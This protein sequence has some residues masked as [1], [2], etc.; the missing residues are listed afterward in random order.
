MVLQSHSLDYY[1]TPDMR[2]AQTTVALSTLV[3]LEPP[4]NGQPC[5][6]IVQGGASGQPAGKRLVLR[7]ADAAEADRWF[8]GI[9]QNLEGLAAAGQLAASALLVLER[10]EQLEACTPG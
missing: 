1:R 3:K 2:G 7:A 6:F 10:L 5:T 4:S 8:V 9:R